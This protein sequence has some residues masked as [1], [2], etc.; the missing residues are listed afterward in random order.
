MEPKSD[1][2]HI[3]QKKQ[4]RSFSTNHDELRRLLDVLQERAF[5]AAD[6]EERHLNKLESQTDEQYEQAK[7]DLRA[8]F[9][10]LVTVSGTDGRKLSG[11]IEDIFDSPNFPGNVKDL[12]LDSATPLRTRY[13]YYPRNKIVLFIDFGRPAVLNFTIMP[14]QETMNESN[15][16]VSGNDVTWVNGVFQEAVD[17]ISKYPTTASWLHRH[18]V[19]DVIVWLLGLPLSFWACAKASR[20]IETGFLENSPFLRAALYVYIFFI[21]LS[22]LRVA[23]HYARWI[24]PLTE[25]RSNINKSLKHKAVFTAICSSI[26][27]RLLYDVLKWLCK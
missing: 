27:L 22:L 19:Y 13:N 16:E 11:T 17:Y 4:I 21:S 3:N 12:I 10:F 5:A 2:L 26:G 18:T 7:K 8:G 25:Y 14:S 20:F 24:W 9:R 23:F 15:I 1:S 6:I